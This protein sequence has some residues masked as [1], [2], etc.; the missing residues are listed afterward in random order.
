MTWPKTG[1]KMKGSNAHSWAA[2][3][4]AQFAGGVAHRDAAAR[5]GVPQPQPARVAGR[6]AGRAPRRRLG[7]RDGRGLLLLA[8][9]V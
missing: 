7:T 8:L 3:H 4:L 1:P 5:Q 2:T 6:R 9:L